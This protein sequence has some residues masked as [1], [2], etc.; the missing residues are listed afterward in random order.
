MDSDNILLTA[1]S[2]K[3]QEMLLKL[4]DYPSVYKRDSIIR[5]E[6]K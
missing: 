3:L 1:S 4:E 2:A 6:Q 5:M